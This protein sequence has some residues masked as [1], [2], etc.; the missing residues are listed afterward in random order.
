[1]I[2]STLIK[3]STMNSK[4]HWWFFSTWKVY[5]RSL[6]NILQLQLKIKVHEIT[7]QIYMLSYYLNISHLQF[8]FFFLNTIWFKNFL[9]TMAQSVLFLVLFPL[10]EKRFFLI[11]LKIKLVFIKLYDPS[12][13]QSTLLYILLLNYS[14]SVSPKHVMSFT[15]T[16][17][18]H[19]L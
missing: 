10:R 6:K 17:F 19:I 3:T 11:I 15:F 12:T 1:M 8:F 14:S 5:H 18:P 13:K 7:D 16:T 9:M 4:V 2:F